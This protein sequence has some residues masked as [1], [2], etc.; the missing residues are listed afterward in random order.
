MFWTDVSPILLV[1]DC[2][3]DIRCAD[4]EGKQMYVYYFLSIY[5]VSTTTLSTPQT[6]SHLP[7]RQVHYL[8]ILVTQ[9]GSVTCLR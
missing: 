2:L 1:R 5:S 7:V 9:G 8:H 3:C 4:R 6:S